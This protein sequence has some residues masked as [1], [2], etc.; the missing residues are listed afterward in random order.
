MAS[1]FIDL[2]APAFDPTI[3]K[4]RGLL[5]VPPEVAEEVA[6]EE[7]NFAQQHGIQIA[8]E[9]RKRMTD[10]LT[11]LYYYEGSEV[12]CRETPEGVEVL[13]VGW[14]EVSNYIKQTPTEARPGVLIR[15]P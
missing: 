8:P 7:A 11:L 6:R 4:P 15:R 13:A 3:P 9:T 12:A 10:H 5:P 1:T 14:D 2:N